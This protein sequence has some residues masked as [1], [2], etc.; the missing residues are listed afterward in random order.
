MAITVNSLG[1]SNGQPSAPL[2]VHNVNVTLDDSYP[3][4]G[5]DITSNLPTGCTVLL[6]SVTP[7]YDSANLRHIQVGTDKKV[8]VYANDNGAKGSEVAATTDCSGH[9]AVE[10]GVWTE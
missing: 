10:I 3:D 7:D 2:R 8:H 4:G 5:Y 6:S 9:T 1:S